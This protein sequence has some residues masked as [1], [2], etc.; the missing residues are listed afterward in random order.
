MQKQ[1]SKDIKQMKE[2]NS[3][4]VSADKTTKMYKLPVDNYNKI[5]TENIT[6]TYKKS[7]PSI[8]CKINSEAKSIA[9]KLHLDDRIEQFAN[10][11]SYLTLKDH[12]ENF[13]NN[14]KC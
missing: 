3:V 11:K 4:Y 13:E 5:L 10:K 9:K 7:D 8:V 6:K 2:S 14:P 12:K 1:L